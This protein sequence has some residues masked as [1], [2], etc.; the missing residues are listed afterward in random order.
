MEIQ[1]II[2]VNN[3]EQGH[4]GRRAQKRLSGVR[5]G[6]VGSRDLRG[7]VEMREFARR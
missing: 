4:T 1:F 2:R 3:N 7:E 6:R 5:V